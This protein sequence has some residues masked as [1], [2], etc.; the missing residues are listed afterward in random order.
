MPNGQFK[1]QVTSNFGVDTTEGTVV[2][3][4]WDGPAQKTGYNGRPYN[5]TFTMGKYNV[6]FTDVT[7]EGETQYFISSENGHSV[8][9]TVDGINGINGIVGFEY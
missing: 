7:P 8:A 1:E 2:N 9:T 4:L 6:L 5:V 3:G